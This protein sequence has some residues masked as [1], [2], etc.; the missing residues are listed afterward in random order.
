MAAKRRAIVR[1]RNRPRARRRSRAKFTLPLSIVAPV[2][3]LG[4]KTV[5][6][7]S[8]H[9]IVEGSNYL[10]GALT[11]YR[12]DWK[13]KGWK[14]FHFERVKD[15][16]LPIMIGVMVHKLAG[17]AGVNRALGRAGVPIFRI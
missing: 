13:A 10:T 17:M 6:M 5:D 3:V 16:I 8:S 4:V 1:Y 2:G 12:P 11:G 9:G 15:G 14:P 7:A